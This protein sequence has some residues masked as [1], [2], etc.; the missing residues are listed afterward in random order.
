MIVRVG[1]AVLRDCI[2]RRHMG[3]CA[4]GGS[5]AWNFALF[6]SDGDVIGG[7]QCLGTMQESK[8][9]VGMSWGGIRGLVRC[10]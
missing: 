1:S 10:A 6:M 2:S 7:R 4:Y 8:V 5:A 3:S 9:Q